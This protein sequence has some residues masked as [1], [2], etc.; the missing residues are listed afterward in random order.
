MDSKQKKAIKQFREIE[1]LAPEI[2]LAADG[3]NEDWKTLIATLMS[4]RTTDALT[5]PVAEGLFAKFDTIE[6]LSR[7]KIGEIEKMIRSVNFYRNKSRYIAQLA[8]ILVKDYNSKVPHNFDKLI[9]LPGVGRKTA[10]VFLAEKGLGTIGVDTHVAWISN[11][12]GWTRSE[13]Q[14]IVEKDLKELFPKELWGKLNWV[15]VRFGQTYKS[16]AKKIKILNRIRKL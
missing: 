12:M 2:R 7:A 6:K 8:K 11:R 10:N 4:A 13:K 1:K 3:W 16:R 15:L 9:E 14:E 5:I